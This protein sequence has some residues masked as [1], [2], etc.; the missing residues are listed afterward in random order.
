MNRSGKEM[1]PEEAV[2]RH[3]VALIYLPVV[4]AAILLLATVEVGLMAWV[5]GQGSK[6]LPVLVM[7]PL[8]W[9]IV[10][11]YFRRACQGRPGW[12]RALALGHVYALG[13][14]AIPVGVALLTLYAPSIFGRAAPGSETL[15]LGI[16]LA[17]LMIA[18]L[19]AIAD[20][21][22]ARPKLRALVGPLVCEEAV[23]R[24]WIQIHG[25]ELRSGFCM[26]CGYDLT[27][28]VSGACPE[29]GAAISE[30]AQIIDPKPA[31]PDAPPP[32]AQLRYRSW[33]RRVL[34]VT[35]WQGTFTVEYNGR[36]AGYESVF[37]NGHL[38]VRSRG[39]LWFAPHFAFH[40]GTAKG[41]IDVRIWPWLTL[42][43]LALRIDDRLVYQE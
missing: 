23:R 30:H 5:P 37:V 10:A 39:H 2:E 42:R 43:R 20:V 31:P 7:H 14:T 6:I 9:L 19:L 35:T 34:E 13:P 24:A 36:G 18:T 32:T 29:C 1:M 22:K 25:R 16:S 11:W 27:G 12:G 4:C 40:L 33:L 38:A 8:V 15:R 26:V 17:L 3:L 21:R 28:N 41:K